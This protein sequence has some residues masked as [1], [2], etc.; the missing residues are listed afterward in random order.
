[1]SKVMYGIMAAVIKAI[2]VMFWVVVSVAMI[3]GMLYAMEAESREV[4]FFVYLICSC[5][6]TASVV[7]GCKEL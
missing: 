6:F 4:A 7:L 1:M 5:G 3:L 2:R